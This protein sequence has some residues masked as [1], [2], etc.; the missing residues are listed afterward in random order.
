MKLSTG[1]RSFG[2][3]DREMGRERHTHR[4]THSCTL[5]SSLASLLQGP[6]RVRVRAAEYRDEVA[7]SRCTRRDIR[8]YIYIYIYVYINIYVCVWTQGRRWK[9]VKT[10]E[11]AGKSGKMPW[12]RAGYTWNRRYLTVSRR[13]VIFRARF[14]GWNIVFFFC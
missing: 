14:R 11:R 8:I 10:R 13:E 5:F 7:I 1:V 4:E 12:R 6:L 9:S 2:D 3:D